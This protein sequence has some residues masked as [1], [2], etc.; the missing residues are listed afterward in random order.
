[1]M[2]LIN[3]IFLLERYMVET[4]V[5]GSVTPDLASYSKMR[6]LCFFFFMEE[7]SFERV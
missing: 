5:E 7:P 6:M 1:M 4:D 3:R 2:K